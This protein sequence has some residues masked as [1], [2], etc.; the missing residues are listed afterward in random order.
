MPMTTDKFS[1]GIRTTLS[2]DQLLVTPASP[3]VAARCGDA[4]YIIPEA[5]LPTSAP[6]GQESI[7]DFAN[8]DMCRLVATGIDESVSLNHKRG[9]LTFVKDGR[10][11][12]ISLKDGG[13]ARRLP[14]PDSD[15]YVASA[16]LSNDLKHA[17]IVL[18]DDS[19]FGFSRYTPALV[20]LD[21]RETRRYDDAASVLPLQTFWL[22]AGESFFVFDADR[23]RV[24]RAACGARQVQWV[25]MPTA[26]GRMFTGLVTHTTE[27]W[28]SLLVSDTNANKPYLMQAAVNSTVQWEGSTRLSEGIPDCVTW[29]P[30]ERTIVCARSLRKQAFVETVTPV[31]M[32]TAECELPRGWRC[33]DLAWSRDGQSA[34][35]VGQTG[36]IV[37]QVNEAAEALKAQRRADKLA[38]RAAREAT[39]SAPAE[40]AEE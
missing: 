40:S 17:L 15:E 32:V 23:E 22:P 20:N 36:V 8:Q 11:L 5:A 7:L 2:I 29:H 38:R 31:G 12:V 4:L 30:T 26:P 37:W 21:K 34:F 25:E 24:A 13:P 27:P 33:A 14:L 1:H 6:A 28:I 19:D 3:V 35:I 9:V 16:V 18:R 39:K 10:V